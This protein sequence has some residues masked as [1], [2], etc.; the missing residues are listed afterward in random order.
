MLAVEPLKILVGFR[1]ELPKLLDDIL[2]HVSVVFLDPAGDLQLVLGGHLRHL[3]TLP[4]QV[5]YKLRDVPPG[6]RD[7]FDGAA[8]HVALRTGD[9]MGHAVARVDDRAGERAVRDA[10]RAPGCGEG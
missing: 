6:D 5:E 8:D 10:V 2:T 7:V 9:D 3:A 1:I 4:H